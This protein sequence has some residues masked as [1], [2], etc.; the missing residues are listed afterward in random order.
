MCVLSPHDWRH[1]GFLSCC[2]MCDWTLRSACPLRPHCWQVT[3]SDPQ[4]RGH[5]PVGAVWTGAAVSL[6]D[7]LACLCLSK[8]TVLWRQTFYSSIPATAHS[9]VH[10]QKPGLS[11]FQASCSFTLSLPPDQCPPGVGP[12]HM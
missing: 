4:Q 7:G 6:L 11:L 2:F 12:L 5:C 3:D 10:R 1:L 8:S 9:D